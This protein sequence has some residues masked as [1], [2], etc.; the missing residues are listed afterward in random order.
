MG[1]Q[2]DYADTLSYYYYRGSSWPNRN[3][4]KSDMHKVAS[5]G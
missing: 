5:Y 3:W 2:H 4:D 1:R